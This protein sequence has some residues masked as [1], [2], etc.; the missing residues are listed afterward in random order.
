[1][2]PVGAQKCGPLMNP[3][4]LRGTVCGVFGALS[5]ML[6]VALRW[7]AATGENTTEIAQ[8]PPGGTFGFGQLQAWNSPGTPLTATAPITS[9]A[10]PLLVT[11][12]IC[13][14]LPGWYNSALLRTLSAVSMPPATR[15]SPVLSRA[16][17]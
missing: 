15:T 2:V 6:R 7:R 4:P 1:M 5:W 16:A 9:A 13:G 8:L 14:E 10:V 11:V 17:A 12:I 3:V